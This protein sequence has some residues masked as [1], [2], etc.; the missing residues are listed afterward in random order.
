M[1]SFV[2][3]ALVVI[4]I[5]ILGFVD[6][7]DNVVKVTADNMDSFMSKQ[8]LLLE[9]YAP[10]CKHCQLFEPAYASIADTVSK[11]GVS[12]GKVDIVENQAVASRFDVDSIPSFFFQRDNKIWKYS[13]PSTLDGI[14]KFVKE[15]Y[16]SAEPMP[17]WSSPIGP[18]GLS[19]GFLITLG[20]RLMSLLPFLSQR[21]GVPEW[22]GFVIVA[23]GFGGIIM[24]TTLV[25]VF[26]SV[27]HAKMD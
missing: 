19:K 24:C 13:G 16:K 20:A 15:G 7:S 27:R 6:G 26:L 18:I 25:G 8:P 5:F 12:V 3:I 10:W 17:F 21:L 9:F 23:V 22:A 14:L 4:A 11:D 2:H 1:K